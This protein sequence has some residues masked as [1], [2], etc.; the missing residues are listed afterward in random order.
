MKF[1][2]PPSLTAHQRQEAIERL[3][4]GEAQADIARVLRDVAVHDF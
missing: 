1:G 3:A 2:R 4:K